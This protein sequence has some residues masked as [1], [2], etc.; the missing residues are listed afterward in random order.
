MKTI[1]IKE[2]LLMSSKTNSSQ[3]VQKLVQAAMLA[4]LS[5]ILMVVV[6]F[7]IFAAAP[8]LEYDMADV[9]V[10]IAS[11]ILGPGYGLAVLLV[12]CA[13]QAF[14]VSASAGVWGFIMHFVSSSALVIISSLVFKKKPDAK[15]LV[16]GLLAGAVVMVLLMIPLNILITPI[17][18]GA[19]RAAVIG[20]LVP[21]IIPFNAIKAVINTVVT[22]IVYFPLTKALKSLKLI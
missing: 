17:Y 13:I 19:P 8:F 4:A 18:T 15:G 20:M 12:T 2:I 7:P 6:R 16:L 1:Y 3:N 10:L 22:G 21:I 9:P 11:L 14:T 5:L